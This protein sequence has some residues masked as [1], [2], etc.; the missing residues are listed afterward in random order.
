VPGLGY[1]LRPSPD[2]FLSSCIFCEESV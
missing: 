2:S 1:Q